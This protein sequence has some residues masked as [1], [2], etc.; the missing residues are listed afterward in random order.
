MLLT[1]RNF[2]YF[3]IADP[4]RTNGQYIEALEFSLNQV[5]VNGLIEQARQFYEQAI[6]PAL[7]EKFVI[8]SI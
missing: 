2:A 4:D 5:R 3:V 7:R 1:G 8:D 6:L